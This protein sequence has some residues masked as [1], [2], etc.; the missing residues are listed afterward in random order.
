MSSVQFR[1]GS[2]PVISR[3]SDDEN[4]ISAS[5]ATAAQAAS[6]VK[7]LGMGSFGQEVKDMQQRLANAGF[8]PG[9]ID[10][11]FGPLTNKALQQFQQ[12]EINRLQIRSGNGPGGVN[13]TNVTAQLAQ[14]NDEMSRGVAGEYTQTRLENFVVAPGTVLQIGSR[15]PEVAAIQEKLANAGFDPGPIDGIYGPL[16][17]AAV[18][19]F[20]FDAIAN[21]AANGEDSTQIRNENAND[22]VGIATQVGL[23]RAQPVEPVTT[24]GGDLDAQVEA[25]Y[26]AVPASIK[27]AH[28][29]VRED[30]SRILRVAQEEGLSQEQTAYVLAT[31]THENNLGFFPEE[32]SSGAQYEGRSDLGNNQPGD[33]VRFKGRGYVQITGRRNYADWS[34][35]LGIDLVNNPELA[36]DKD[37]AAQILVIGMRDGTFTG[38]SLGQYVNENQSDF[39]NARRVVNGT[40]KASLFAGTAQRYNGALEGVPS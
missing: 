18:D 21:A 9:P 1:P 2:T 10:G 4:T 6:S 28:P 17:Q 12:S 35:R 15:G 26:D 36:A 38:R 5:D 33:G 34:Q 11:D 20:Q 8:D 13:D 19:S 40:D 7:E 24:G 37:I 22:V 32:L 14:L 29:E 30:I 27:R 25:I 39:T 23:E 16:T 3:P 31:A